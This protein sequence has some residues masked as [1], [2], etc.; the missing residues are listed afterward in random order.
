MGVGKKRANQPGYVQKVGAGGRKYW[1]KEH[2]DSGSK[3]SNI[4]QYSAIPSDDNHEQSEN[5]SAQIKEDGS[6]SFKHLKG[7]ERVEAMQEE[8]LAG[9]DN[10]TEDPEQFNEFMDFMRKSYKYSV[11]NQMLIYAQDPRAYNCKTYKQWAA[12]GYQVRK[13]AQSISVL[14]PML[15]PKGELKDANGKPVLDKNG[16]PV[17]K[18][19]PIGYA[20]YN[21][22]SAHDLDVNVKAPPSSPISAHIEDYRNNKNIPDNEIMREDLQHLAQDMGIRIDYVS[23]SDSQDSTLNQHTGG[24]V[25]KDGENHRVVINSDFQDHAQTYTLAHEMSHVLCGHL[26]E[27]SNKDTALKELEAE[28]TAYNIARAYGLSPENKSFAYVKSWSQGDPKKVRQA[29]SG[30]FKA[31]GKYFSAMEERIMKNQNG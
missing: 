5:S 31:S 22:F 7:K 14:R 19:M 27:N 17:N 13:G 21:V 30:V 2:D 4:Q 20:G 8:I 10:L 29:L 18:M 25:T 23:A 16:K 15:V 11:N 9:M 3:K 6:V 12:E 24:Y 28:T 26:D 1:A